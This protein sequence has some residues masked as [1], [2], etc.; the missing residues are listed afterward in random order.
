MRESI[1]VDCNLSRYD[2]LQLQ[3][4]LGSDSCSVVCCRKGLGSTGTAAAEKESDDVPPPVDT[5]D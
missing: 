4:Y 3:L 1:R 5:V 2:Q